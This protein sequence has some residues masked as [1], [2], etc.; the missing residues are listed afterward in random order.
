MEI[1]EA[2]GG[3]LPRDRAH[4][5]TRSRGSWSEEGGG[6]GGGR[7]TWTPRAS[8]NSLARSGEVER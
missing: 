3:L 6:G 8:E 2:A 7:L 1:A 5:W 4:E